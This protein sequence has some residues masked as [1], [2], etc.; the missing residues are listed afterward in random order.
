[1]K[2]DMSVI[3]KRIPENE[4]YDVRMVVHTTGGAVENVVCQTLPEVFQKI[5]DFERKLPQFQNA[6]EYEHTDW[7]DL[8]RQNR[9]KQ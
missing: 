6:V 2:I 1:M 9:N 7:R 8:A 5:S 3:I 4:T